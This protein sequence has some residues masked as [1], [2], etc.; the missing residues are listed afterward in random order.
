[1]ADYQGFNATANKLGQA[2]LTPVTA[3]CVRSFASSRFGCNSV[4]GATR[5]EADGIWQPSENW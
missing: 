4:H 2:E 3:S 5:V 1:M